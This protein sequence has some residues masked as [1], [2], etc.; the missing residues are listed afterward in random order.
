MKEDYE[1]DLKRK[2]DAETDQPR[3]LKYKKLAG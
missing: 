1:A 3:Q 2:L